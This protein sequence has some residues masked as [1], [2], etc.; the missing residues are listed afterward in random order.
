[1]LS[2][3]ADPAIPY[4][5]RR[6]RLET[7]EYMS[8]AG[9]AG[10]GFLNRSSTVRIFVS[11]NHSDKRWVRI[12][13][14]DTLAK[15]ILGE[16]LLRNINPSCCR[17]LA[18]RSGPSTINPILRAGRARHFD[19]PGLEASTR[20]QSTAP[21]GCLACADT[22]SAVASGASFLRLAI[23]SISVLIGPSS[24]R[25]VKWALLRLA[26]CFTAPFD[27]H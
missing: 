13:T 27:F 26:T 2:R 9:N 25:P 6:R 21:V 24:Q 15:G 11:Y 8:F 19:S 10:M 12:A 18:N 7:G 5:V 3:V 16:L 17:L 4:P 22:I 20:S 23:R 1:M 14:E